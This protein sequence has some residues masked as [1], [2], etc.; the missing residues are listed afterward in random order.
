METAPKTEAELKADEPEPEPDLPA[1][2]MKEVQVAGG[3]GGL[4]LV[5]ASG[6]PD[7]GMM[8]TFALSV[9]VGSGSVQ[10]RVEIIG[11]ARINT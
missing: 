1:I 6:V 2:A 3:S 11:H 4:C 8:A 10:V 5:A 7:P 9:W